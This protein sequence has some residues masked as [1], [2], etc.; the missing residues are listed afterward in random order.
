MVAH[1]SSVLDG[2]RPWPI[3]RHVLHF[4]LEALTP[5]FKLRNSDLQLLDVGVFGF[6]EMLCSTRS[7]T[8]LS[9]H[10]HFFLTI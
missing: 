6:M 2:F 9:I 3:I 5:L 1:R 4:P 8:E 10:A 7:A